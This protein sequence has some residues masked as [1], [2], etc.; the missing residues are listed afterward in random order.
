MLD[1]IVGHLTAL[2]VFNRIKE[3]Y[4]NTEKKG[5]WDMDKKYL[6]YLISVK[7]S[8][9][10]LSDEAI[11]VATGVNEKDILRARHGKKIK[12]EDLIK[13]IDYLGI[14]LF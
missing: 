6:G 10:G 12:K 5:A 1:D 13:I 4:R 7:R 14:V 11:A 8:M 9:R 2:E 3:H